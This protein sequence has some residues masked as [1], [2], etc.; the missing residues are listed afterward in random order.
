MANNPH[1]ILLHGRD[2]DVTRG[3][4]NGTITPGDAVQYSGTEASGELQFTRLNTDDAVDPLVA[5]ESADTGRGIDQDYSD[6]DYME[7]RAPLPGERFYM[8]LI[9]GGDATSST[10]ANVSVGDL[11]AP[12]G[13]AGTLEVAGT[14]SNASFQ[15]VEAV[16][17]SGAGSGNH[18]RIKVE[19]L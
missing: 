2:D 15:A 16:D 14:G 17:N 6:G 8:R 3:V 19:A 5:V 18:V 13:T 7:A 4:A 12:S 11:L 9:A 10:D 1:T